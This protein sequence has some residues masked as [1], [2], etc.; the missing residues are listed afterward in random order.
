M[1]AIIIHLFRCG[2]CQMQMADLGRAGD[3]AVCSAW[4]ME[5]RNECLSIRSA[6]WIHACHTRAILGTALVPLEA[7][8]LRLQHH[9]QG[10]ARMGQPLRIESFVWPT[11]GGKQAMS[12]LCWISGLLMGISFGKQAAMTKDTHKP[13]QYCGKPFESVCFRGG[14]IPLKNHEDRCGK[15]PNHLSHSTGRPR[16]TT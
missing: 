4:R 13:C 5:Q 12:G 14:V 10:A 8:L 6:A 11:E 16:K 7:S 2:I 3:G 15:N 9:I 1:G